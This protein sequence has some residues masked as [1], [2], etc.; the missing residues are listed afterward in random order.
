MLCSALVSIL[1][2]VGWLLWYETRSSVMEGCRGSRG[3]E[4]GAWLRVVRDRVQIDKGWKE[5]S[6]SQ[7]PHL[8]FSQIG[9]TE[10]RVSE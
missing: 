6:T 1:V 8:E 5:K 4:L 2:V 3:K 7:L 10:N 9:K